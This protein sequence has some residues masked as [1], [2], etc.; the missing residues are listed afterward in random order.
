M[1]ND[2]GP[3]RDGQLGILGP[4]DQ[5]GSLEVSAHSQA[6]PQGVRC[7]HSGGRPG[8]HEHFGKLSRRFQ[9]VPKGDKQCFPF[10]EQHLRQ[11]KPQVQKAERR[12]WVHPAPAGEGGWQGRGTLSKLRE[13][14]GEARR[15]P[16]LEQR[17]GIVLS[18]CPQD[19]GT[20]VV[21]LGKQAHE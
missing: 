20:S 6:L 21:L 15:A 10:Q 12:E 9:W 3:E 8:H 11:G 1:I 4:V 19:P 16:K 13:A 17:D 18:G 14:Q 5:T 7:N 2:G